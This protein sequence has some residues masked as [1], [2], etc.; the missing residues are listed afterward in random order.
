MHRFIRYALVACVTLVLAGCG[1]IK[2]QLA[3]RKHTTA[4][5]EQKGEVFLGTVEAVNPE[6]KF[7]LVRLDLR[8]TLPPGTRLD[9]R[10]ARGGVATIM[11]T[12][13]NKLNFLS[14]DIVDGSPAVGDIVSL[15]PQAV[16]TLSAPAIKPASAP[17]SADTGG[18]VRPPPT[19][20]VPGVLPD[21]AETGA[22]PLPVR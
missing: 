22:L 15:S 18:A 19:D 3:S 2:K 6:K 20:P 10:S 11:V 5:K 16:A 9:V 17:A 21:E 7:V 1:L 8:R 4:S 14:A 12:P 13:E